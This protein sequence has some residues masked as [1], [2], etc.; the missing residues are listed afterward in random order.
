MMWIFKDYLLDEE[1]I[2]AL[3]TSD[4]P[5]ATN[6]SPFVEDEEVVNE[7]EEEVANKQ[8]FMFMMICF[9]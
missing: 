3:K 5:E 8:A 6:S 9:V 1:E 4:D 7:E 2:E